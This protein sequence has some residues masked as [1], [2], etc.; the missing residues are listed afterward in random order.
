MEGGAAM[1]IYF[2][3]FAGTRFTVDI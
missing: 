3:D 1:M 2:W